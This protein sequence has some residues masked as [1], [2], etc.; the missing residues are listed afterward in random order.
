MGAG[1]SLVITVTAPN[2]LKIEIDPEKISVLEP[3]EPGM[4]APGAKS[5][6][7]VDG[8]THAVKETVA[9]IDTMRAKQ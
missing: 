4:Y 5:V 9:Q 8:E 7:R 1:V 2:G 6:I 3:A